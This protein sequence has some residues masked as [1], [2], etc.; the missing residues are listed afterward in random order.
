MYPPTKT[1][2]DGKLRLLY[3]ANPIAFIAEQAGGAASDGK[4]RILDIQANEIH[5]RTP[6]LVGSEVEMTK[7]KTNFSE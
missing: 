4:T 7:F 6:L 2:S 5:Q 1:H 3:E